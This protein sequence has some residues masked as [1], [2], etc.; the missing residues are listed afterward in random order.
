MPQQYPFPL[1]PIS[2]GIVNSS[3]I[4]ILKYVSNL[5]VASETNVVSQTFAGHGPL[6]QVFRKKAP[7]A[8]TQKVFLNEIWYYSYESRYEP[9]EKYVSRSQAGKKKLETVATL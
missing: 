8:R 6:E 2:A 3:E 4:K 5:C 7:S 9:F 1:Q